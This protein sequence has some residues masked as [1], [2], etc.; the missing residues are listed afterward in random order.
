M[1]P[2]IGIFLCLAAAPHAALPVGANPACT[3]AAGIVPVCD[4]ERPEDLVLLGDGRTVI[5]SEYG[6]LN[7]ARP[8]RLSSYVPQD[9]THSVVYPSATPSTGA[10]RSWGDAVCPAA[11]GPE[12]SPHGIY[13]TI[14][15]G[16]ERLYAVNHGGR[17]A[18]EAFDIENDG[19]RVRLIWRGCVIA[20]A[21]AWFNDLAVAPDGTVFATHMVARGT[22]EDRLLAQEASREATG[23]VLEWRADAGWREVPGT[24]GGLPNGIEISPDGATLYVNYYFGDAVAAIDHASGRR[25]WQ[26]DMAAPDNSTWSANGRL[27]VA[28]HTVDLTAIIACSKAGTPTCRVP[29]VIHALDAASGKGTLVMRGDAPPLGAVTVALQVG[30][31]LLLGSF[32]GDRLGRVEAFT[33]P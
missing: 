2:S 20:P 29:Y 23:A 9:D 5:V 11:P 18:I 30:T 21:S 3:A 6:A 25:L 4:F 33:M 31:R 22:A 12:F 17:E 27:L 15:N 28:S 32:V 19:R 14:E 26:V 8:G 1:R 16:V 10:P 13:H 7:G 24:H